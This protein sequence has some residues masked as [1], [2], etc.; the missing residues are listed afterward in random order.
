MGFIL[1]LPLADRAW[2]AGLSQGL[3]ALADAFNIE[4]IGAPPPK[5]PLTICISVFGELRLGRALRRN[6]AQVGDDIWV[7]GV[8]IGD[9]RVDDDFFARGGHTSPRG[10][11][12]KFLSHYIADHQY[13]PIISVPP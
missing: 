3:F 5:G 8:L 13:Q 12:T 7:P 1:A 11:R 6:A 10:L 9:G 2:L 4:L